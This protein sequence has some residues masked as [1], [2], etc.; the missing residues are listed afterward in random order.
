VARHER[1]VSEL[2]EPFNMSLAAVSKHIKILEKAALLEQIPEGRVRRCRFNPAPLR[3]A[4]ALIGYLEQFWDQQ[5]ASLAK[6]LEQ[7][8]RAKR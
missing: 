4:V 1:T 6:H 2:A 5:L 7:P 8:T 3:D